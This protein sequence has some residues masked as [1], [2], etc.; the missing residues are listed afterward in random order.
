M[1]G[2]GH[3]MKQKTML[4][5]AS[6][7]LRAMFAGLCALAVACSSG[8][9]ESRVLLDDAEGQAQDQGRIEFML[10]G[11]AASG[12]QY[13]LRE[14]VLMIEG[15]GTTLMLDTE[16][17]PDAT[18]MGAEVAVGAYQA[19]LQSGWRLERATASGVQTVVAALESA[20]PAQFTVSANANVLVPL[21]FRTGDDVIGMNG[22]FEVVLEVEE[23]TGAGGGGGGGAAGGGAGGGGSGAA[24]CGNGV[25]EGAEECDGSGSG[26]VECDSGC[27]FVECGDGDRE[28]SEACDDGNSVSDDGCSASCTLEDAPPSCTEC[29]ASQCSAE[30]A[31]CADTVNAARCT[32]LLTCLDTT[33]CALGAADQPAYVKACI[34]GTASD[35]DCAGGSADG[36]CLAAARIA[37]STGPNPAGV[38]NTLIRLSE[39]AYAAGDANALILCQINACN[40]SCTQY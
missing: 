8:G 38:L 3:P 39:P 16:T 11:T 23:S 26:G 34:C 36:P 28:G 9:E 17:T 1:D 25:V 19:F 6:V 24:S 18:S 29:T 35:L 12:V 2:T 30:L 40:P 32:D 4:V 20:N 14:A 22:A 21:R 15:P 10:R 37:A 5:T 13:R 31:G 33:D 27:R 7:P